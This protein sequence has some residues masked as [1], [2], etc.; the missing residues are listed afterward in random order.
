[1]FFSFLVVNLNSLNLLLVATLFITRDAKPKPK[2]CLPGRRAKMVSE[3]PISSFEV[4]T[5]SSVKTRCQDQR[6]ALPAEPRCIVCGRYGEYICDATEDDICSLECKEVVLARH[7]S[8]S[9]KPIKLSTFPLKVPAL[10]ECF[11]V[12]DIRPNST[13]FKS[14]QIESL[15]Y[16]IDI[17]VT[18]DSVPPP[19]LS[20]STHELPLK[21]QSNLEA[22]GYVIPTPIQMQVIPAAFMGRNLLV[23]S[24]TGSGKTA[25]FLVPLIS[26]CAKFRLQHPSQKKKPLA[27][28][29]APTRELCAQVEELAK[30]L[31]K[32]LPFKTALIVGGDPIA[33]QIYRIQQGIELIIATAGRLIDL[34]TKQDI[35]LDEVGILVLDEVDCM[36]QRGFRD[37]VM[38]VI[39]A[40]SQPQLMMFSATIPQDVERT[41]G[42]MPKDLLRIS[43]GEP[44]KPT[45]TVKQIVI[46]VETK[47]KKR[48]LFDILTSK[49][50]FKPPAVVFVGS[51]M[52]ADLLCEAITVMSGL[53]AVAV[54]GDKTM[55]E[56]RENLKLFL[57]GEVSVL[58]ATGVLGRGVDMLKVRQVII[59]DMPNSMQEY[60]HQIG[61]ASRLGIN[62]L[63]IVFIN[64]E[65]KNLFKELVN[66]LK[67]SGS[68]LPTAL[69]NSPHSQGFHAARHQRKRQK[70]TH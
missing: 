52:G 67:S 40:L 38:Q 25:S 6:E 8:N 16:R 3:P 33:G 37:E 17:H 59:F 47:H 15:R 32:G 36:L 68:A 24:E 2:L 19:I 44:G 20:F 28:V 41:L 49:Q 4:E 64:E 54:H 14:T 55:S 21:L 43:S 10:D 13:C 46:W 30:V 1:C 66:V 51:K 48:K 61:R 18:G 65:D 39:H 5:A 7:H 22:A 53:R 11:Y 57:T 27:I 69:L 50:H 58:V 26:R 42:T 35:E 45:E 56:R 12:K 60:V 9:I 62:G 31:G 63:A 29:L 34:L 70:P 23:S